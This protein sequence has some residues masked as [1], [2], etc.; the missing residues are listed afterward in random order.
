MT[1]TK[2]SKIRHISQAKIIAKIIWCRWHVTPVK[3]RLKHLKWF[4]SCAINHRD[5]STQ[6]SY[7]LTIKKII[8]IKKLDWLPHL[9]GVWI[10]PKS[11]E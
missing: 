11:D 8:A 9:S 6:Y 7:Y 2:K 10:K 3:W 1:G 4:L 5:Q